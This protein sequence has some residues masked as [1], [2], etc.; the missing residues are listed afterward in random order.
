MSLRDDGSRVSVQLCPGGPMLVRGAAEVTD[1]D[2]DVHPV[3]RP[4]VA[5][6]RCR[7]SQRMPW[8]DSSHKARRTQTGPDS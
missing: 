6:C 2:G 4:V 5:L 1:E 8:C 3:G 7:R